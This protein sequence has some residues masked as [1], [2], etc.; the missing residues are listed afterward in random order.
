MNRA[1]WK[2]YKHFFKIRLHTECDNKKPLD[3]T[4]S[5]L[6]VNLLSAVLGLKLWLNEIETFSRTHD[7]PISYLSKPSICGSQYSSILK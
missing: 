7:V 4:L 3:I 1:K 5:L 6:A 2:P